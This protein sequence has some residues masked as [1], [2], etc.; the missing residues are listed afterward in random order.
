MGVRIWG[1]QA[2]LRS[3]IYIMQPLGVNLETKV[4]VSSLSKRAD[5]G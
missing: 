3:D 4:Y 2:W 1:L 5:M